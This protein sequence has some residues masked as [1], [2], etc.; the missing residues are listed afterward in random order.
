MARWIYSAPQ[1]E[2][3]GKNFTFANSKITEHH[4]DHVDCAER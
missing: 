4:H 2:A 1:E 3:Y